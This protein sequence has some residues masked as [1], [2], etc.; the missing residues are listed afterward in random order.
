MLTQ[1]IYIIELLCVMVCIHSIYGE[2]IHINRHLVIAYL[3]LLVT[4]N[5]ANYY[6]ENIE[7][8]LLIY[9]IIEI[10]CIRM[11]RCGFRANIINFVLFLIILAV[12]EFSSE[13]LFS[14]LIR[15]V[16]LKTLL[17]GMF[18]FIISLILY[19]YTKISK[20][21][22]WALKKNVIF[23]LALAYICFFI[24]T[25]IVQFKVLG[26]FKKENY[27][28]GI[29]FTIF[30]LLMS[31]QWAKYQTFYEEKEKELGAYVKGTENFGRL[32]TRIRMKQHEVNNHISAIL[33]MHY[34]NPTYEELV[35]AQKNYCDHIREENKYTVLLKLKNSMLV[36]F[37]YDKFTVIEEKKI[38]IECKLSVHEYKSDIPEYYLIE[39]LGILLDNAAE[40]IIDKELPQ[41]IRVEIIEELEKQKYIV[42][43]PYVV[44]TEE[45]MESWF[46]YQ[47]SSKGEGRGIGLYHLKNLC[48]EWN[49][50][51]G[52]RNIEYDNQNWI[53]FWLETDRKA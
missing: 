14:M 52:Y 3:C 29:P 23:Y 48:V 38:R 19:K 18:S 36:G 5:V 20:I 40:A 46:A 32:I 28:I 42:R 33:S 6:P 30:I 53:E 31:S 8:S 39:M 11:F 47:R 12:V 22:V 51:L 13:L 10:Y 4:V 34:V 7:F 44:T 15:D 17:A 35:K 9:I 27:I 43:N 49:C 45:E 26:G 16:T 50:Y 25:M 2:S 24:C 1:M 41:V 21:S 37:L